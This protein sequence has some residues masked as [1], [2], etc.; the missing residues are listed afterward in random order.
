VATNTWG[1]L[2]AAAYDAT[3]ATMFEPSV[4]DPAVDRLAEL[5][6]GGRALE[7]AVGT[8]RIALPLSARGVSVH[9]IELSP[10]MVEQL[11]GKPG[12]EAVAVTLGDM[13]TTR[14]AG[15]F[16]LV[17]LVWNTITN[18]TT[19]HEQVAVFANAAAH[20]APGGCFVVEVMVP[21][22]RRLPP[23]EIGRVFE[24]QPHH[25]GI[26]TFDDHVGQISWS[27]HW[28]EV[29][30]RL[31]RDSAPYRYVWPSE[32][33]LMAQLA[34]LRVRDRWAGWAG[35]PFTSDSTEQVAVFEK[36][37]ES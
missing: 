22:L 16:S 19:Q 7:F 11:R 36:P 28:M 2:T 34:G 13:A 6:R 1:Q 25:I 4:L 30:G 20:L 31:I 14:V 15:T 33:D 5:A 29:D 12:S 26:E 24:L 21:P 18:V 23:G 3:S 9:G 17:Y 8:G 37:A 32:L 10:H 35:E 27:H